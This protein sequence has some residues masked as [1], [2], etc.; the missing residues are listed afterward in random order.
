[1]NPGLEN[2][3]ILRYGTV[4]RNTFI[5]SPK[6]LDSELQLRAA[7]GVYLAGQITG[8]EGYVESAACGFL[9]ALLLAQK[10]NGH[11]VTPPP[12]NTALGGLLTHLGRGRDGGGP[13]AVDADGEEQAEVTATLRDFQPSNIT[14]A[15]MPP[16]ENRKLKKRD[17]YLALSARAIASHEAWRRSAPLLPVEPFAVVETPAT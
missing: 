5:D 8:V 15:C 16:H 3:E 12:P 1:M 7:P 2:V 13:T 11:P 17:R 14:W 10:A 9:V 6:L 4:H